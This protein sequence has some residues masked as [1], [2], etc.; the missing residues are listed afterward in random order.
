MENNLFDR[1]KII[2]GRAWLIYKDH[3]DTKMI[4]PHKYLSINDFNEMG[5]YTLKGLENYE[6]F[7]QQLVPGD[8]LI[9]GKNFGCGTFHQQAIDCFI[10]LGIQAILAESFCKTYEEEAINIG[11]P[12]LTYENLDIIN[13]ELWDRIRV[14]FVKG[15]ITNLRNNRSTQINSFSEKQ[16]KIYLKQADL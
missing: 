1:P 11:F 10:S 7:T 8:I 2:E 5:K 4:F 9:T 14:N 15:L 16:M 3:I 13:L 12:V 6:N